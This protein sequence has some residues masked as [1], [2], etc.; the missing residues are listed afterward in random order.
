MD[1][2]LLVILVEVSGGVGIKGRSGSIWGLGK[3]DSRLGLSS[4]SCFNFVF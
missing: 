2:M 1:V 4:D 3:E